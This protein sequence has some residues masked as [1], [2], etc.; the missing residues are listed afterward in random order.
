MLRIVNNNRGGNCMKYSERLLSD[1]IERT[2]VTKGDYAGT[3]EDHGEIKVKMS[4]VPETA[5]DDCSVN[6]TGYYLTPT[7]DAKRAERFVLSDHHFLNVEYRGKHPRQMTWG[8]TKR[9]KDRVEQTVI[10]GLDGKPTKLQY[11]DTKG[12]P[13]GEPIDLQQTKASSEAV[14]FYYGV[15]DI[16]SLQRIIAERFI[17]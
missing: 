14:W 2:K 7:G 1:R 4:Y 9:G 13:E 10:F 11:H 17:T 5:R 15:L 8:M 16:R 3:W 12:N 6:V